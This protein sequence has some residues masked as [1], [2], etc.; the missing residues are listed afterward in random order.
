MAMI[1]GRSISKADIIKMQKRITSLQS[2]AKNA[3]AEAEGV[4][5]GVVT[6]M[7]VGGAAFGLGVLQGRYPD[8]DL[9]GIPPDLAA[10]LVMHGIAL[11][12]AGGDMKSHFQAF[13]NG[14]LASYLTTIG[15]GIGVGMAGGSEVESAG[16]S[17]HGT[18][19]LTNADLAKL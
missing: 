11:S 6:S 13:G 4:M 1:A 19:E 17:V 3:L 10:A 8:A 14:A 5:E 12:G 2:R 7:E 9:W 16:S 18:D 15:R